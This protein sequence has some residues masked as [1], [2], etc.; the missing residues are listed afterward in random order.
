MCAKP[1]FLSAYAVFVALFFNQAP[2]RAESGVDGA[3]EQR[4]SALQEKLS[5]T[6]NEISPDAKA[7]IVSNLDKQIKSLTNDAAAKRSKNELP[8]G[9]ELL[10]NAK[11]VL[12][13]GAA[14]TKPENLR[15]IDEVIRWY[16]RPIWVVCAGQP[17][18]PTKLSATSGLGGAPLDFRPV[19]EPKIDKLK[20]IANATGLITAYD[21]N[22]E[23]IKTRGPL[24]TAVAIDDDKILTNKHVIIDGNIGYF[25]EA[26]GTWNLFGNIAVK[27]EF[28]YEYNKCGAPIKA[29]EVLVQGIIYADKDLDY[30]VLQTGPGLPP[31]VS[32]SKEDDADFGD[33]V[34]VIGYP[35]RPGDGTTFLTPAQIDQA[36]S[37][38][39]GR[40]PFPAERMAAG[41]VFREQTVPDG[42]F[43]HD[44]STW[45]GNSGS[46]VVDLVTGSVVGLHARGLESMQEGVGYNEAVLGSRIYDTL[47]NIVKN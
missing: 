38:P 20:K 5:R 11:S 6:L 13:S 35:S 39:N 23:T 30:A 17:W 7:A 27:V 16:S 31:K 8:S 36:F 14:V 40:T 1:Y 10:Q 29:K 3:V 24:A 12:E 41:M 15:V 21:R 4:N 33:R 19:V 42:Y 43:A 26:T 2:L 18:F 22:G 9:A 28:P 25:N 45:G 47:T 46:V 37:A 32:F 34:V 44:A